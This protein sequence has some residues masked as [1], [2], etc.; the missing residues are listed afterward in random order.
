MTA[1]AALALGYAA[2]LA[3]SAA[4]LEWAAARVHRR[5]DAFRTAGFR[6]EAEHDRWRCPSDNLLH[7]READHHRVRVVY[8]ASAHVC[9]GCALKPQCTDSDQGRELV[10]EPGAWVESTMARFHRG[11]SL[12]LLLLA[13]LVLAAALAQGWN[14]AVLAAMA[15]VAAAGLRLAAAFFHRTRLQV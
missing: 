13:E 2:L 15:V 7:R 9:N 4:A 5:A 1:A 3:A 12:T 11:V 14:W 10:V 8:R 6:Y